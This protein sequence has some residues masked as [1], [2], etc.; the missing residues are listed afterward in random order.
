VYEPTGELSFF[1]KIMDLPPGET[2]V[3]RLGL[4]IPATTVEKTYRLFIRELPPPQEAAGSQVAIA[5]RF[6]V[7]VF[8]EPVQL[9]ETGQIT[10]ALYNGTDVTFEAANT[11]NVHFKVNRI[12]LA[13]YDAEGAEVYATERDGWYLLS[14]AARTHTLP[15]PPELCARI[16]RITIDIDTDRKDIAHAM[17]VLPGW[18]AE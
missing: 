7:P 12:A 14:G 1:P 8:V 2:R 5:V 4:R 17:E 6:G 3:I 10:G 15:V 16:A 9:V 18:C 11:G 13:A